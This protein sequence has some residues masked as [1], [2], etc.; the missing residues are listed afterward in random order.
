[1]RTQYKFAWIDRGDGSIVNGVE[2]ADGPIRRVAVRF[3]EGEVSSAV[4]V[5]PGVGSAI[6]IMRYRNTR[7]LGVD[8]L[9]HLARSV[10]ADRF[11]NPIVVYTASD[12]GET[13]N[14]EDVSAFLR[15]ELKKDVT[16]EPIETQ[17]ASIV[18]VERAALRR[19]R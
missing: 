4:E 10:E 1:M 17:K 2:Q 9:A 15:L 19:V 5:D 18:D 12:F 6:R 11:G 3:F 7:R 8:D 16:R 14:I 13:S